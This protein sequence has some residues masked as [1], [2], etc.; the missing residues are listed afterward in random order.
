MNAANAIKPR[1]ETFGL[2]CLGNVSGYRV[3]SGFGKDWECHAQFVA[4][5][6]VAGSHAEAKDCAQRTLRKMLQAEA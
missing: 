1:I 3:V 4:N 2:D 5:L 6:Y